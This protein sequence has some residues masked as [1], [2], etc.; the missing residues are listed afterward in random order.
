[1]FL[2]PSRL[3]PGCEV[4][5][6][7]AMHRKTLPSHH[8]KSAASSIAAPHLWTHAIHLRLPTP[9][10][11]PH[12]PPT[13]PTSKATTEGNEKQNRMEGKGDGIRITACGHT[14]SPIPALALLHSISRYP[15]PLLSSQ[16]KS[17]ER[18]RHPSHHPL[19]NYPSSI[20]AH[21]LATPHDPIRLDVGDARDVLPLPSSEA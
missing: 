18:K 14:S 10:I 3:Q 9:P 2:H 20:V 19:L 8:T 4:Q 11:N 16:S 7:A 12:A 15:S 21:V 1:M 17:V 5:K 13:M 6:R